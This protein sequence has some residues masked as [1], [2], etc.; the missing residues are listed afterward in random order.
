[1]RLLDRSR[2]ATST[3]LATTLALCVTEASAQN[4]PGQRPA[5]APAGAAPAPAGAA[6]ASRGAA[7]APAGA[8]GAPGAAAV[9]AGAAPPPRG[10][11]PAPAGPAPA[12]GAAAPA[13]AGAA[14]APA[15]A[16]APAATPGAAV[17]PGTGAAAPAAPGAAPGEPAPGTA[18]AGDAAAEAFVEPDPNV[19]TRDDLQGLVTDL[20]N[21][22]FQW[23]RERDLHTAIS[24]RSLL[25]GGVVQTRIGWTE[26][27]VTTATSNDRKVTFDIGAALLSFNGILYKDYE[28][29]R[30]LTYSLRFGASP[31]QASNNSFL[32]LLDAQ[33]SYSVLPTLAPEDWVLQVTLGQQLLPFGLEVPASEE[34]KPVITNAQFTTKLGLNRRDLGLI[35]RGDVLPQVDYGYN[36]RAPVLAYAVG[37]VNGSGP[38]T[39]DD[40]SEKDIIGRLAFTVPSDYNSI[41]RQIT[42]GGSA[43]IGWQNTFL[44]DEK[45]TLSGKGVKRRYG[46]DIYYNH[47]PIG[48]TYEFIYGQDDV[49]LGTTPE[50][51]Q[52]T[53]LSS[54]SHVATFFYNWGEQFLRGYRNQGRYDDWWPKTYQPFVRVDLFDPSTEVPE[55]RVDV[56]TL[57][58][59]L[60]FAETTKFQLNLNRRDDRTSKEGARHE[61]LAQLQ[62]G[63]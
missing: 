54:L 58:F 12:P 23:Q 8:A 62:G 51:P 14:Q 42:L 50:D 26:Q 43:Y 37:L 18:P 13:P 36:Y 49:T 56:Y 48:V 44:K 20:E 5:P 40:N 29:G 31:Q 61:V 11:T 28:E 38:N 46:G 21:F 17:T 55:N 15:P 53:R 41:L 1:M 16:G 7:P 52:K 2:T 27:P 9:P 47:Y 25:I 4:P 24:T 10:A 34:L 32:N 30:N 39:P 45:K 6:P 22:K 33:L 19:A 57:G 35:I 60:F 59:N 63:F 3:I